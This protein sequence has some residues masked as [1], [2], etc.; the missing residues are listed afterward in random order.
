MFVESQTDVVVY[1]GVPLNG[2]YR[3]GSSPIWIANKLKERYPNRIFTYGPLYPWQPDA[4]EEIDRMVEEDGIIGLKFYPVDLYD[5]ELRASRLDD[6]RM[7][8]IINRARQHGIKMIAVHKAVP[9]GPLPLEPYNSLYDL[10]PLIKDFPDMT[11]EIVHGGAAFL[12][13][14]VAMLNEYPNVVVNLESLPVFI[15]NHRQKFTDIMAGFLTAGQQD[16]LFYATGAVGGHPQPFLEAFWNFEMP[17]DLPPLTEAMKRDILANN[18][19]RYMG[20]NIQEMKKE[21]A[22]DEF[23]LHRAQLAA[24]WSAMR[25]PRPALAV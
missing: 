13:E 24:P 17:D 7:W 25:S 18:F 10:A 2:L 23:G 14:T 4:L 8:E 6:P 19:A 22:Q 21:L 16:R 15:P 1:H 3:D 20:W 12:D 5:G 11:F 9:L